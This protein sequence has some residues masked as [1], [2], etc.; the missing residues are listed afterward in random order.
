MKMLQLTDTSKSFGKNRAL[1]NVSLSIAKGEMVGII[2]QFG[3]GKSTLLR[4]INHLCVPDRGRRETLV[5]RT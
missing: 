2:G 1:A 5:A 4:S 3:A